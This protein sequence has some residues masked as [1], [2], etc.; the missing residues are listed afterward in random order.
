[1]NDDNNSNERET[2]RL[3]SAKAAQR[4]HEAEKERS[5]GLPTDVLD[6]ALEAAEEED[7]KRPTKENPAAVK[8][9]EM[10]KKES[11]AATAPRKAP[12]LTGL[13]ED[14]EDLDAETRRVDPK[15]LDLSMFNSDD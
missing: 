14:S 8:V 15:D 4:A 6:A 9:G 3:P 13:D 7:H 5:A 11:E 12:D 2:V 10:G 1:M